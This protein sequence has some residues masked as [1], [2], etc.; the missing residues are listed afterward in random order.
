M[1]SS[2]LDFA[3]GSSNSD[4]AKTAGANDEIHEKYPCKTDLEYTRHERHG[5]LQMGFKA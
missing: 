2:I 3:Q 1:V 5:R 4:R